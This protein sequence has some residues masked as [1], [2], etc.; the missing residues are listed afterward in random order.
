[1]PDDDRQVQVGSFHA[2]VRPFAR[3]SVE[4]HAGHRVR[5]HFVGEDNIER[6]A[7]T[8][9]HLCCFAEC[10]ASG[11]RVQSSLRV[12]NVQVREHREMLAIQRH[13]QGSTRRGMAAELAVPTCTPYFYALPSLS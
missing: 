8:K 7:F 11:L 13:R 2:N 4:G 5:R 6:Q 3:A 1:M 9:R 12:G 10:S